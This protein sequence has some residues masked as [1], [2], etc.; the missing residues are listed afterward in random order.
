MLAV[1]GI[2]STVKIFSADHRA[3][4]AAAKAH[5]VTAADPSQFTSILSLRR[6]NQSH[7]PREQRTEEEGE[8]SDVEEPKVVER[9]LES[10]KRM[11]LMYRIT[12]EN[13]MERR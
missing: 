4:Q 6:R 10:R 13:D 8:E 3:R 2:D 5:G 12:S 7:T 1:S 11:H 9:G